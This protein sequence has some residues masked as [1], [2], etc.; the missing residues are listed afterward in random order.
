MNWHDKPGRQIS[1]G[2]TSVCDSPEGVQQ[3]GP[4]LGCTLLTAL[5]EAIAQHG[6]YM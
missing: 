6:T 4:V 5:F 2:S 3:L 1:T